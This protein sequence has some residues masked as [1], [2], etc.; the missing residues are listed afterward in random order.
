M[1]EQSHAGVEVRPFSIDVPERVLTDL[2]ARV[3][4]TRWPDTLPDATWSDGAEVST[5]RSLCEQWTKGFDWR[6]EESDLNRFPQFT[7]LIDGQMLHFIHVRSPRPE[8]IPLILIH[9]WPSSIV[10]F[11]HVI[12]DLTDPAPHDGPPFH[13]VAPSL[14]GFGFSGPTRE[15]GWGTARMADAFDGLMIRLGYDRYGAHGGDVGY[16]VASDLGRRH[17]DHVRGIHLDLGGVSLAGARRNDPE[18]LARL[19]AEERQAFGQY[20]AFVS[21]KSAYAS[22]QSS[23]P[24]T[25]AFALSDSPVGQLA[26]I[27]EKFHEWVDPAHPVSADDLLT[28]VTIYWVTNTSGS[29]AWF[30]KESYGQRSEMQPRCTVPTGVA[31]FPFDLVRPIRRWAEEAYQITHWTEMPA[32]GHFAALERPDLLVEDLRTFFATCPP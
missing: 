12:G 2:Y 13:V 9:G 30:Y 14:P 10:E 28:N 17:P 23:R 31:V 18:V 27:V 26:W 20:D 1:T 8:A 5:V 24:Q 19:T 21:D 25:L 7:S 16:A 22:L 6:A 32:G 29:S 15:R 4:R 11:R 3:G